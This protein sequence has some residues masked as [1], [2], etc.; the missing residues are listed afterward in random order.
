MRTHGLSNNRIYRIWYQ[1]NSRCY[2]PAN[3]SYKNYGGR[4]IRVC[5]EWKSPE[6]FL[7]WAMKNGYGD[8]LSIERRNVNG[9]YSPSNCRWIPRKLQNR[10]KRNVRIVE[11]GGRKLTF[12]EWAKEIGVHKKTVWRR[13]RAGWTVEKALTTPPTRGPQTGRWRG[14]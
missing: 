10:N 4:G 3:Q 5:R 9:N 14:V 11:F 2:R 8:K 1:M 12:F 6:A 7:G 13:I